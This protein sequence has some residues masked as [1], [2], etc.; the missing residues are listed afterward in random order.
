MF[1]AVSPSS[2]PFGYLM[3]PE[4]E[5]YIYDDEYDL[6][7]S[8]VIEFDGKPFWLDMPNNSTYKQV[9]SAIYRTLQDL[10]RPAPVRDW[11]VTIDGS[12]DIEEFR[13][14]GIDTDD[15]IFD[16]MIEPS[17]VAGYGVTRETIANDDWYAIKGVFRRD[18]GGIGN[19]IKSLNEFLENGGKLN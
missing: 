15:I 18:Y 13:A 14:W 16:Y 9:N 3:L 7:C 1:L 11:F 6:Y 10:L 5:R 8:G 19:G 17:P 2:I 12:I 4:I